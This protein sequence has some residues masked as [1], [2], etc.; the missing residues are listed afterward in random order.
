MTPVASLMSYVDLCTPETDTRFAHPPPAAV[1]L[2][3]KYVVSAAA[4]VSLLSMDVPADVAVEVLVV[5][6]TCGQTT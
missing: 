4:N 6:T 1:T 2:A 5:A 3:C